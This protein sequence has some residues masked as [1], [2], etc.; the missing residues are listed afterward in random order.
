MIHE[1]TETKT[2]WLIGILVTVIG[3][4]VLSAVL[5]VIAA[6]WRAS[7]H[8]YSASSSLGARLRKRLCGRQKKIKK[9][10]LD[11]KGVL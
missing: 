4:A 3:S 8:I 9:Q 10:K 6:D 1:M 7:R 11:G 2:M 5:S